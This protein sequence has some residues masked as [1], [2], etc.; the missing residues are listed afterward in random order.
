[1]DVVLSLSRDAS[2]MNVALLAPWRESLTVMSKS[3]IIPALGVFLSK[4]IQAF[5]SSSV[6]SASVANS[7]IL[8]SI[9]FRSFEHTKNAWYAV[10]FVLFAALANFSLTAEQNGTLILFFHSSGACFRSLSFFRKFS[11]FCAILCSVFV[12]G[13]AKTGVGG[14]VG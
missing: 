7:F 5:N 4:L 14:L 12:S 9:M 1:M 13:F 8:L 11:S 10:T 6:Y 3:V 2:L